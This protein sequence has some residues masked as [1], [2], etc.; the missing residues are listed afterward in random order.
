VAR[1][2]FDPVRVLGCSRQQAE[3]LMRGRFIT[4]GEVEAVAMRAYPWW[5]HVHDG[6]SYWL[7]VSQASVILGAAPHR[8][9]RLLEQNRLPHVVHESGVRLMR[10]EDIESIAHRIRI[11][12]QAGPGST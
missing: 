9:R 6:E 8:V 4:P 12:A 1:G 2:A 11:P 7:T 10:R 5:R 3:Q